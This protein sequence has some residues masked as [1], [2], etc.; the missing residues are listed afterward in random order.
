MS[1]KTFH[2][3]K[4]GYNRY[5]VDDELTTLQQE[6]ASKD[7]LLATSKREFSDLSK[8][9]EKLKKEF[10]LLSKLS[11]EKANEELTRFAIKEANTVIETAKNNADLLIEDAL[12]VARGILWEVSKLAQSTSEQKGTMYEEIARIEKALDAFQPI[13]I[14]NVDVLNDKK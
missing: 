11:N 5:E 14:P 4:N 6:I 12:A 13:E 9:Y 2:F 1:K 8:E 10:D 7:L 3:M